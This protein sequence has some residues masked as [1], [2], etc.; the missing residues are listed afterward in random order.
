MCTAIEGAARKDSDAGNSQLLLRLGDCI[1][2]GRRLDFIRNMNRIEYTSKIGMRKKTPASMYGSPIQMSCDEMPSLKTNPPLC[3]M[4]MAV[5]VKP[6]WAVLTDST[7]KLLSKASKPQP[8]PRKPGP[9][10]KIPGLN[11][12]GKL[13]TYKLGGLS[14]Y[15]LLDGVMTPVHNEPF[16]A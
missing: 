6:I 4:A 16:C 12:R 1:V 3:T 2:V 5:V 13:C 10:T 8:R 9:A 14:L 7:A 15:N 11:A